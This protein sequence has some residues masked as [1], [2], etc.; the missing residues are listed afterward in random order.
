[1]SIFYDASGVQK[2]ADGTYQVWLKGLPGKEVEK[3]VSKLSRDE[4]WRAAA[5]V[6]TGYRPPTDASG[7]EATEEIIADAML[8]QVADQATIDPK[9]RMLVAIDCA[10]RT[11]RTLTLQTRTGDTYRTVENMGGW[12]HIAPETNFAVLH[13]ALCR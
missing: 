1:M 9:V 2:L 13:G 8:E 12:M 5:K 7:K 10:N 6:M 4:A 11:T 3:A